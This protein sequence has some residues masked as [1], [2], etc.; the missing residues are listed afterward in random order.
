M[1]GISFQ[2][3]SHIKLNNERNNFAFVAET[4]RIQNFLKAQS[5][6]KNK[7]SEL[8]TSQSKFTTI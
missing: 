6:A 7:E 8:L 1:N 4:C 5:Y 3:K 2:C